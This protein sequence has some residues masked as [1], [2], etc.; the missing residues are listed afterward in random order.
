MRAR[1]AG[2]RGVTLL[3]LVV[4]LVIVGVTSGAV[5]IAARTDVEDEPPARASLESAIL[6]ARRE[7]IATGVPRTLE[8]R[9]TDRGS[10]LA[11]G[12]DDMNG[13]VRLVT[14]RPDGGVIADSSLGFAR[15]SGRSV[16]TTMELR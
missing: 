13:S 3:E 15:L 11:A 7:A 9:L 12:V 1:H 4:A 14:I 10:L 5:L 6:E 16:T 8:L 2:R